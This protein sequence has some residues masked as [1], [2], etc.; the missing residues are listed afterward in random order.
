MAQ[1]E[2]IFNESTIQQRLDK[3]KREKQKPSARM[4]NV[5]VWVIR[6][7]NKTDYPKKWSKEEIDYAKHL[8][9]RK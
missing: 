9:D 5:R 3:K 4:K 8:Q 7:G 6:N 2:I 1:E